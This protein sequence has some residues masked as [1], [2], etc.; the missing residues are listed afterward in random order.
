MLSK[1]AASLD[2]DLA[3]FFFSHEKKIS[4]SEIAFKEMIDLVVK[5]KLEHLL[6]EKSGG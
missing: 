4:A 6:K 3:E 1:I 2:C 5:E